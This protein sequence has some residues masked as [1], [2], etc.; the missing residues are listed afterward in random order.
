MRKRKQEWRG[1]GRGARRGGREGKGKGREIERKG[2]HGHEEGG[3]AC[4][5][6][7]MQ[8]GQEGLCGRRA[9]AWEQSFDQ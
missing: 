9:D 2:M 3:G 1:K 8:S 7:E 6:G 4:E 5:V